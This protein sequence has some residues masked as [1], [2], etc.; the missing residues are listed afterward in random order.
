MDSSKAAS[1]VMLKASGFDA[2]LVA[3]TEKTMFLLRAFD[4]CIPIV[5]SAIALWLIA[6]YTL[7]EERVHEI[8]AELETRRGKLGAVTEEDQQAPLE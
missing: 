6:S 3:Q 4:V 8:R 1:S 2:D 7:S 5:T